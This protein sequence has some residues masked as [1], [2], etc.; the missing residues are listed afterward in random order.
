M[1]DDTRYVAL[2]LEEIKSQNQLVLE[3]VRDLPTREEFKEMKEDVGEL[4][5]DVKI[6]KAAVTDLSH[7]VIDHDRRIARLETAS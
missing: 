7:Q 3:Y 6:I 1:K 5:Q 2:M 4:K